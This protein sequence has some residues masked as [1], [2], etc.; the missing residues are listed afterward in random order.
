[1]PPVHAGKAP[2]SHVLYHEILLCP[3]P[4]EVK[5]YGPEMDIRP[6]NSQFLG[7]QGPVQGL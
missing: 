5:T 2:D 4:L 1:M 7:S 3:Y 6:K